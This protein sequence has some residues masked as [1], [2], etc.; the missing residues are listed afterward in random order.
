MSVSP[1]FLCSKCDKNDKCT[2]YHSCGSRTRCETF[3]SL[4]NSHEVSGDDLGISLRYTATLYWV[5]IWVDFGS[6]SSGESGQYSNLE[7]ELT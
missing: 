2:W 6:Y 1:I 3:F 5:M 4:K 7:R